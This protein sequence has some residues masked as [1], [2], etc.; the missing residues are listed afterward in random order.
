MYVEVQLLLRVKEYS[1]PISFCPCSIFEICLISQYIFFNRAQPSTSG[2]TA[3]RPQQLFI[4]YF[5]HYLLSILGTD[6]EVLTVKLG[7]HMGNHVTSTA[8]GLLRAH[9][10]PR[11]CGGGADS[12]EGGED[13]DRKGRKLEPR[14]NAIGRRWPGREGTIPFMPTAGKQTELLRGVGWGHLSHHRVTCSAF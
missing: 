11:G 14:F 3:G 7:R 9:R 12:P 1:L 2:P 4:D 5:R 10:G 13:G 6:L 8:T